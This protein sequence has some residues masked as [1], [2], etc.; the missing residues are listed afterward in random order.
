MRANVTVVMDIPVDLNQMFDKIQRLTEHL[1]HRQ[2]WKANFVETDQRDGEPA[3]LS[4]TIHG[5]VT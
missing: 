5:D 2:I 3:H 1:T 4:L